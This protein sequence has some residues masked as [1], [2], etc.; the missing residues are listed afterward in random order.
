MTQLHVSLLGQFRLLRD[1]ELVTTMDGTRQQ[2]LLAYLLLNRSSPILRQ[3][4]AFLFWPDTA[5]SQAFTNLRNLLHKLR[6]V[7]P[8]LDQHLIADA[9]TIW[10]PPA[11]P[12][13]L[14]V[15]RFEVA[16]AK[17]DD[18][19]A[20]EQ[21][22]HLYVGDLLPGCYDD[23]IRPIRQSLHERACIV[24]A[25]LVGMHEQ[26]RRYDDA[27]THANRLLRLEPL[28]ENTHRVL[29]RLHALNGDRAAAL[30]V[31]HV[32]AA[33]F[34][35]E[36][37]AAPDPE[38]HRQYQRLM[39]GVH[40][41]PAPSPTQDAGRL[42]LIGRQAQWRSLLAAWRTAARGSMR[43]VIVQGDA[44]IGK[45]R[46]AEELTSWASHQ[47]Y[48]TATARCYAAEGAPPYAPVVEWLRCSAI[49]S[50]LREVDP[51]WLSEI[52]RLLPDLPDAFPGLPTPAP[53][54][55]AWQ[56]QH[57]FDA[58]CHVFLHR[59]HPLLLVLDDVH[60]CDAV[61][62]E[63]LHYLLRQDAQAAL[64]VVVTARSDELHDEHALHDLLN[65][66]R[67]NAAVVEMLLEPLNEAETAEL[68]CFAAGRSLA[69][70]LLE[71]LYSES[72]GNPL[73]AVELARLI[74]GHFEQVGDVS[75]S[76][77]VEQAMPP[78]IGAVLQARLAQLPASARDLVALAA[79]IGRRFTFEVL[80]AAWQQGEEALVHNLDVL[81]QRKIV[82]EHGADGYDFTHGKL[83]DTAYNGLSAARRRLL[84]RRIANALTT[85]EAVSP[86][87][88]AGQVAIHY[89]LAGAV[90]QA[91]PYYQSAAGEATRVYA[92]DDAV[93]LYRRAIALLQPV[94]FNP[95]YADRLRTLHEELGDVLHLITR[96]EEARTAY[97]AALLFVDARDQ[98]TYVRLMRLIGNTWREQYQYDA[99]I[100]SYRGALDGLEGGEPPVATDTPAMAPEVDALAVDTHEPG[101]WQAWI[102]VHLE[103]GAIQYWTN[104]VDIIDAAGKRLE[105]AVEHF[106]SA[107]QQ[108]LYWRRRS[109]LSFRQNQSIPTA[110]V[111][112]WMERSLDAL[113]RAGDA[114]ALPDAY[115]GLGFLRLWSGNA[116]VA[117]ASL[118]TALDSAS[119]IG[120][121]N[122]QA[123]TLTYLTIAYRQLGDGEKVR[124]Y[125]E[126][127]L[128]VATAA[129]MP[130]YVGTAHANLVWLAW[131][132]GDF[133]AMD[134][135]AQRSLAAWDQLPAGHASLR[136]Q[137]TCF[138]PL[139]AVAFQQDRIADA[140]E[141]A[142]RLLGPT[143]QRLPDVLA[144]TLQQAI[145]NWRSGE[146]DQAHQDFARVLHLAQSLRFL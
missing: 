77:G 42:P 34:R 91:V 67:R 12:I 64:L 72:E 107:S 69:P 99:A 101:W 47:G 10:L 54:H 84:H 105:L 27:I 117:L 38:T 70:A 55:A 26:A 21:A 94:Q 43:C 16:A 100:A 112:E 29:M 111:I 79:V 143:Q 81:W 86:A 45:S 118:H 57:L 22:A 123:R 116:Q 132:S 53:L 122:L 71:R 20:L 46:L 75:A 60:W 135:H 74:P 115:F 138:F 63:W 23:W 14:D 40:V 85:V 120:N 146:V 39:T 36:L 4:L 51:I 127:S 97:Q 73:F 50:R 1:G 109:E 13:D 129:H 144:A 33:T 49:Q 68:T 41:E 52:S 133:A 103:L 62:L 24:L 28:H 18:P 5:E 95:D 65:S 3:H 58:L 2:S 96:Y 131:W 139:M 141:L 80:R 125:A 136:F 126:E 90:V 134:D 88:V 37:D 102:Q 83:R 106:G 48:A 87:S 104:Q 30:H 56:R 17:V 110:A 113:L 59:E 114:A 19:V 15:T 121:T 8:E 108:A 35:E 130:E 140:V 76:A 78:A 137:W 25:K 82:R 128:A 98:Q 93:H 145:Q 142:G 119:K 44:G 61:T 31:Y 89:E 6:R 66:L 124:Q 92:N 9:L 11:V 7:L 32:C